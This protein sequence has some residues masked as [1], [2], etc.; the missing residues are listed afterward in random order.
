VTEGLADEAYHLCPNPVVSG[1][2]THEHVKELLTFSDLDDYLTVAIFFVHRPI[3]T[4][5][6]IFPDVRHKSDFLLNYSDRN[7]VRPA[8]RLKDD[9]QLLGV[10]DNL[11]H[12]PDFH[13]MSNDV[14]VNTPNKDLIAS[15]NGRLDQL[16]QNSNSFLP[17]SEYFFQLAFLFVLVGNIEVL[18]ISETQVENIV[19]QCVDDLSLVVSDLV[20]NLNQVGI[21]VRGF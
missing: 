18:L 1:H 20:F 5:L 10:T 11:L 2:V 12:D 14:T 19:C 17:T 6:T 3:L 9:V 15:G 16:I 8:V 21:P 13:L 7:C 4:L